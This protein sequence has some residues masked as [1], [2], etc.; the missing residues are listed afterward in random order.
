MLVC[1]SNTLLCIA[2]NISGE[3]ESIVTKTISEWKKNLPNIHKQPAIFLL[4]G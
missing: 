4:Q 1:K 2:V 3:N